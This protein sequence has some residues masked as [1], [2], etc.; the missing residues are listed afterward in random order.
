MEEQVIM[1][2][3]RKC[4]ADKPITEYYKKKFGLHGVD[5]YCKEC[6]KKICSDNHK[7]KAAERKELQNLRNVKPKEGVGVL[8][9]WQIQAVNELGNTIVS[10]KYSKETIKEAYAMYG[11]MVEVKS[12]E[13]SSR[14]DSDAHYKIVKI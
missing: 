6:F 3:C 8:K 12:F 10:K 5:S 1:K 2:I 13:T 11:V 7:R 4:G 14:F 9:D